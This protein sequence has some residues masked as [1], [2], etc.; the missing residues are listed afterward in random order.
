M[1]NFA[2]IAIRLFVIYLIFLFFSSLQQ[3]LPSFI[4]ILQNKVVGVSQ[5]LMSLLPYAGIWIVYILFLVFLWK[6]SGSIAE[7]VNNG[8]EFSENYNQLDF[9]KSLNIGIIILGIFII[10]ET[11]PDFF[12]SLSLFFI[13][14]TYYKDSTFT[15]DLNV[16]QLIHFATQILKLVLGLVLINRNR[17]ITDFFS[18]KESTAEEE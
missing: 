4:N 7:K 2:K 13:N 10:I 11:I 1:K 18:S 5:I 15:G 17:K 16:R 12:Q 8:I 14:N 3:S 9:Q 6:K